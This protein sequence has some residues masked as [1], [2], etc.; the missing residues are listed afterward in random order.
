MTPF[1]QIKTQNT[2]NVNKTNL[3]GNNVNERP[4]SP[5]EQNIAKNLGLKPEQCVAPVKNSLTGGKTGF[6]LIISDLT[7]KVSGDQKTVE[8]SIL[9]F[10]QGN[11]SGIVSVKINGKQDANGKLSISDFIITHSNGD[12]ETE[13]SISFK[14]AYT[15]EPNKEILN[16]FSPKQKVFD[17]FKK[18]FKANLENSNVKINEKD[19][20]Q[21]KENL[22]TSEADKADKAATNQKED[23]VN[24]KKVKPDMAIN[25]STS[26][27]SM[28]GFMSIYSN[29]LNAI[30]EIRHS[31]TD[32]ELADE[33]ADKKLQ[34]KKE[35]EQ[36]LDQKAEKKKFEKKLVMMLDGQKMQKAKMY[37]NAFVTQAN[38][39]LEPTPSKDAVMTLLTQELPSADIEKLIAK[40]NLTSQQQVKMDKLSE[41]FKN[42]ISKMLDQ[43]TNTRDNKSDVSKI[44]GAG[45][46]NAGSTINIGL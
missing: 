28:K 38:I 45:K 32:A 44:S 35:T 2:N 18:N 27:D 39:G 24:E 31:K 8:S 37:M 25:F 4:L 21:L 30:Y 3:P 13:I 26:T 36:I 43:I 33:A 17:L 7:N 14:E 23:G 41:Q 22:A 16:K 10:L 46:T 15:G 42:D 29:Y 19:I 11:D 6:T 20:Q 9:N 40:T 5:Q 34:E 1:D 12:D